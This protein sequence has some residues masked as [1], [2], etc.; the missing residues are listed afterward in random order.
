MRSRSRIGLFAVTALL[1]I[2]AYAHAHTDEPQPTTT[3]TVSAAAEAPMYIGT[4]AHHSP[5]AIPRAPQK[6]IPIEAIALGAVVGATAKR[7]TRRKAGNRS[8]VPMFLDSDVHV[9]RKND[10]GKTETVVIRG[11]VLVDDTDLEEEEIDELTARRVI[12]H[13]TPEEVERLEQKDTTS[14]REALVSSQSAELDTLKATQASER[15]AM[16][17][18]TSVSPDALTKLDAKHATAVSKLQASHDKALAKFDAQ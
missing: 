11:G 15:A 8:D 18:D 7:T 14:E 2:A 10:D 16:Q 9:M 5:P 12:R 13:A 17:A 4:A 3:I 1:S 6:Q